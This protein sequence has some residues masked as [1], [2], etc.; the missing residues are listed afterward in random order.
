MSDAD[1]Q[2]WVDRAEEAEDELTPRLAAAFNAI[3]DR[4][5][6]PPGA[7]APLGIHWCLAPPAAR[8]SALGPD[9]HPQ[10]GGFLP[11]VALPRRMWAGGQLRFHGDLRVGDRVARRSRIDAVTMK[12]GGSGQLC[13]VTVTH[14]ITSPR[15]LAIEERQDIVYRAA[16][17]GPPAAPPAPTPHPPPQWRREMRADPVKLFRYSAITFNGHRIHYDRD[18]ATQVEHYPGLVVHG[19]LQA[20][21]LLDFA[22][23][24]AAASPR[25]FSFRALSPLADFELFSLNASPLDAGLELWVETADGRRTMQALAAF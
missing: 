25:Q 4:D 22:A 21:L 2:N 6:P 20:T 7:P 18:Y 3:F 15:G 1:L 10:R 19:P 11:P 24:C 9:G 16:S 8:Q 13:F 23:A 14:D 17:S 5:A 12:Q